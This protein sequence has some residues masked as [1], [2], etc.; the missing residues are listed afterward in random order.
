METTPLMVK[1]NGFRVGS[2]V[3]KLDRAAEAAGRRRVEPHGE[4]RRRPGASVVEP[5]PDARLKPA[6]S[7]IAPSVRC[8]S[9]GVADRERAGLRRA[10]AGAAE[11]DRPRAG[12]HRRRA[13]DHLGLRVGHRPSP[14]R[15]TPHGVGRRDRL[16]GDRSLSRTVSVPPV[17]LKAPPNGCHDAPP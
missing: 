14:I 10:D 12:G 7:V 16:P 17:N 9:A 8:G 1:V 4:S 15:S 2:L 5:K 6:G 3:A 13:V 11:V